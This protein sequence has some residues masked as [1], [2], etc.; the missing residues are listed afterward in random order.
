L[1]S[2]AKSR[3]PAATDERGSVSGQS[4]LIGGLVWVSRRAACCGASSARAC[5]RACVGLV[6]PYAII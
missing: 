2:S 4:G 1:S 5:G 6:E 3:A